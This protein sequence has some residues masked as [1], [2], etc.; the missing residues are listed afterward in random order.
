M[1]MKMKSLMF[2]SLCLATLPL[3]SQVTEV[4]NETLDRVGDFVRFNNPEYDNTEGSPYLNE[5]FTPAKIN[6]SKETKFVRFNVVENRIEVKVDKS[7]AL[8]LAY[9]DSYRINLLDGSDKIYETHSYLNDNGDP[10]NTFF[11]LIHENGKFRLFLKERI[12]YIHKPD[13]K[14]TGYDEK[15]SDKFLKVRDVYYLENMVEPSKNIV[16][17]PRKKKYL[18]TLFKDHSKSVEKFI[19]D[20]KL[21]IDEKDHLILILDFYFKE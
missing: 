10:E 12:K 18:S 7:K 20:E 17:I 4:S 14:T 9:S 13:T 6:D 8:I 2:L 15:K 19:K 3:S 5:V 11:E 16:A 1:K 21:S